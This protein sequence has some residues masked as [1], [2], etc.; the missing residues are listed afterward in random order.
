MKS[1]RWLIPLALALVALG[2]CRSYYSQA[3]VGQVRLLVAR[4]SIERAV[5][6]RPE[7]EGSLDF[8]TRAREFASRE[9]ALPENASYRRY[10]ELGRPYAVWNVVAAP[11]LSMSPVTWCFPIAGCVSYR[12]YFD[13]ERA[14]RFGARLARR[15]HD[16]SVYGV[17]AYSTLGWF[18]DPLLSSFVALPPAELAG[19]IFHELAH[20]VVY[21]QDDTA[22]NE[23][24]ATTV[25]ESGLDRWARLGEIDDDE[26]EALRLRRR[27]DA[28]FFDLA[29]EVRTE[30]EQLYGSELAAE[31]KRAR[32]RRLFEEWR[33][34]YRRLAAT[35]DGDDRYDA[36]M[37]GELNNAHL[38]S[39]GSY[40]E[41]VPAFEALLER[42]R[43]DWRRFY[44]AAGEIGR[45]PA[46]E[47][48]LE[49]NLLAEFHRES[50][51]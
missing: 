23:S 41:Y 36:W 16:V 22:F 33:D 37:E 39:I 27:H 10:V 26:L 35:W 42:S 6:K 4:Q 48:R 43:G 14:R 5:E 8:A 28:E 21:V 44:E 40:H 18:A 7:L 38:V 45:L 20:Q 2:A 3:V 29:L 11:E 50:R 47:R 17:R 12:G 34:R 32:K 30:F 24:F 19:L 1:R 31:E 46:D 51:P 15:G 9:L 25:E 13:E 49:L